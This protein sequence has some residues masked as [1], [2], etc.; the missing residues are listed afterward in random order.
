[1]TLPR[2]QALLEWARSTGAWIVEDDYDS[3]FRYGSRPLPCLHGLDT[4]GRVIYVG[5]FSKSLFP[6]L[7]LGFLVVPSDLQRQMVAARRAADLH[8]PTLDQLVLADL[9]L[10]GHF[11]R[12]IRRMRTAYR[13]RR[14]A[15]MGA[16][17]RYCRGA[18]RLRPIHSGLH[19]VADLEDVDADDV[20]REAARRGVEVMPISAYCS[21]R[22]SVN[23]LVIG[24]ACARPDALSAGMER[25]A[26][27][28]D[29]ARRARAGLRT[30]AARG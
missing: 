29:A 18:L 24:F 27:A 6:A 10:E 13:E 1:M 26:E 16:A 23:G 15:L 2:R 8:P 4:D 17:E 14:E 20:F 30:A 12:H 11:D 21:G 7:R 19:A 3:E 25:L 5:S 28:I 9:M 22:A